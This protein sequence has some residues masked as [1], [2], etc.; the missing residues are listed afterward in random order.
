M[1]ALRTLGTACVG[2]AVASIVLTAFLVAVEGVHSTLASQAAVLAFFFFGIA[3]ASLAV[4]AS[5]RNVHPNIPCRPFQD[6]D[7]VPQPLLDYTIVI[8]VFNRPDLLVALHRRIE[9][10]LPQ[11]SDCGNGEIV[12]VND[13][14]T[15]Q[16]LSVA[17]QLARRTAI[18]MRVVTQANAGVSGARNR[19]FWEARGRVGVVIDSDCLPD[20]GWLPAMIE[21]ANSAQPTL[22]FASIYSDRQARFPLEASP[23]G[24]PFAG[25]S[26]AMRVDEY[27]KMGGNFQGFAGASRD[28][29]D[30]YLCA[31]RLGVR[32]LTLNAARVWHPLRT[33]SVAA[34]YRAGLAHRYDGLLLARHGDPALHFMGDWLLGG[35]FA[36]HY[37]M[38]LAL[39][40]FV[41]LVLYH[42]AAVVTG[43][44][45][46]D[47][48]GLFA[49]A[50]A[51]ALVWFAAI[52][53]FAKVFRIGRAEFWPY[54]G[55]ALGYAAGCV[56]GRA[57]GI[58]A[59]KV[60]LL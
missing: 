32:T 7:A 25:A 11:W 17:T 16:T 1:Y 13:G 15:D 10:L 4:A 47:V 54:A 14:S 33:Q 31:R 60:P 39:Y 58:F 55:D 22:A 8:P 34:A 5:S 21:A 44:V 35:S 18:P 9:A 56:F 57:R 23:A 28:D 59:T 52:V 46:V 36:G 40:A 6:A 3:V 41:A 45:P 12:V 53:A 50:A 42:A 49:T 37:P 19:G 51:G 2:I 27:V 30:L 20:A 48:L 43:Q 38:S 24:A 29:G 26:F